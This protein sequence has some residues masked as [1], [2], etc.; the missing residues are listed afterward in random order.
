MRKTTHT[1]S[2]HV[3]VAIPPW[4][5]VFVRVAFVFDNYLI[6]SEM[7]G[8]NWTKGDGSLGCDLCLYVCVC[9][10]VCV[11]MCVYV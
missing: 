11:C 10:Y 7:F 4:T 2:I 3:Q 9:V 5:D 6:F 8:A 1:Q